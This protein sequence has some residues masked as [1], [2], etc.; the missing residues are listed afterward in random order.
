MDDANADVL[1]PAH[2]WWVAATLVDP[3]AGLVIGV[4][5]A[6]GLVG[7]LAGLNG[8][9]RTHWTDFASGARRLFWRYMA[10]EVLI[11]LPETAVALLAA[12]SAPGPLHVA[13]LS[14][15]V[16]VVALRFLLSLTP[17]IIAIDDLPLG[18]ALWVSVSKVRQGLGE[19][20]V[21]VL[22]IGFFQYLVLVPG[23]RLMHYAWQSTRGVAGSQAFD[24]SVSIL[25]CSLLAAIRIWF[26]LSALHWWTAVRS[27]TSADSA[28][29]EQPA[30]A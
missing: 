28:A 14:A 23:A 19:A 13:L 9:R 17:F 11:A 4:L 12:S 15:L 2:S 6:A 3:L 1:S 27:T 30:T 8:G 21:V 20:L 10:F 24:L 22:G 16:G 7:M 5:V 18:K 26:C 29:A 25:M